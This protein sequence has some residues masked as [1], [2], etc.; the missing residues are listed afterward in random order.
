MSFRDLVEPES[1]Y[2]ET[3]PYRPTPFDNFFQQQLNSSPFN[4]EI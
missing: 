2:T 1:Y 3:Y 4:P